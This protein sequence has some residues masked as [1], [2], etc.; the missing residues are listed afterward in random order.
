MVILFK[1]LY[2]CPILIHTITANKNIKLTD[3]PDIAQGS[4]NMKVIHA[5][6]C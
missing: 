2:T 3:N 5:S 6:M 4:N 1:Q